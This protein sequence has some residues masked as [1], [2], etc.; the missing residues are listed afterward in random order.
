MRK[1]L[2]VL[3]TALCMVL[4]G[5][6]AVF[7]DVEIVSDDPDV[8]TAYA[9]Y[10][11]IEEALY[12]SGDYDAMIAGYNTLENITAKID[13]NEDKSEEWQDVITNKV[14]EEKFINDV[15][16]MAF[17]M[18]VFEKEI[19]GET[20]L[21]E[22]YKLDP[23]IKKAY[24]LVDTYELLEEDKVLM[25]DMAADIDGVDSTREICITYALAE[26]DVKNIS[27]DVIAVYEAYVLVNDAISGPWPEDFDEA[28]SEF[29]KVLGIFNDELDAKE[30]ADLAVLLDVKDWE[31]AYNTIIN[32]WINLNVADEMVGLYE[33]FNADPNEETAKAFVEKYDA[34]YNDPEYVDEEMRKLVT[35]C[36]DEDIN[37][38]YEEALALLE[39]SEQKN[40]GGTSATIPEPEDNPKSEAE[41]KTELKPAP[42]NDTSPDTSDNFN[43]LPFAAAMILAALGMGA[44]VV[45]RRA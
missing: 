43:V 25:D 7:A 45:R 39:A 18:A 44:A 9:A 38:V 8:Q 34:I 35:A 41:T 11:A 21:V 4:A 23:D 42:K 30:K 32:D 19:E 17:V 2:L 6:A 1:K 37:G 15:F 27:P 40:D 33:A 36:F 26:E 20:G 10:T 22:A 28:V 5:T 13:E 31:E 24:D 29:E 14:G 12:I 16:N 3:I